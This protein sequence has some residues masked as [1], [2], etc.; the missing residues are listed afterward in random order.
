MNA[1]ILAIGTELLLGATVDTNSAYMARQLAAAGV[2]LFRKTVVGDNVQRIADAINEALARAD[3][4]ICTGGLGPT[5]D[6]MTR[7]AVAH[8]FGVRLEFRDDLMAQVAARFAAMNRPMSE[9]N[10]T[11]AYVPE[12]ARAI[13]N[14][15]GT[16]PAF[17]MEDAR[18]T[19]ICLPGVPHEMRWLFEH[20]VLPYLQHERGVSHIILVR[21]LHAVG[22]GESVIGE[23]I[24][25]LMQ[26]DN[27]TVGIS[28]KQAQYELR[29]SARAA[30]QAEAEALIAP[31]E[32]A[33]RERL[34]EALLGDEP[35]LGQVGRQLARAGATLAL[36][37][38]QTHAPMYRALAAN[39]ELLAALR[40][41]YIHPLDRP[42]NAEAAASLAASGAD[43]VR[44][45]W[46]STLALGVQ[47]ATSPDE[48]GFTTVCVAL[49]HENGVVQQSR[50]YDLAE[51][52]AWEFVSTLALE[53]LRQH[54]S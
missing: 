31:V 1:E 44:G 21:T 17:L 23:R 12:G 37:E 8:A 34:G 3:L 15:R 52:E 25:D 9:S 16:A 46:R 26:L 42:A 22:L 2:G 28:A 24:A 40:G 27:P 33:I 41:V 45:R 35:L 51:P 18:G 38:G 43:A 29:V 13:E 19:V 54:L 20:A 49:A 5:V 4:V 47:A 50:S 48:R 11:Q 7:A 30:S 32:A 36:Y 39:A 53:I 6:D 14:P 10:R